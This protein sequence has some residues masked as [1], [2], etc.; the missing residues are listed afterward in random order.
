MHVDGRSSSTRSAAELVHTSS[1]GVIAKYALR[2]GF[3]TSNNE[4]EYETLITDLM[5]AK[6]L[7]MQ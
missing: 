4:I 6:K 1:E 5:I 2:F 7:D 3:K